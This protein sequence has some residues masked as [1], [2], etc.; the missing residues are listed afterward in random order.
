MNKKNFV[1]LLLVGLFF[2]IGLTVRAQEQSLQK[3]KL[4]DQMKSELRSKKQFPALIRQMEC[5]P[6]AGMQTVPPAKT[7]RIKNDAKNS[8]VSM[9][10]LYESSN[11]VTLWGAVTDG[12]GL[13][14]F[15]A[16]N[17]ITL[18]QYGHNSY[19]VINGGAAIYDGILHFVYWKDYSGYFISKTLYE[20]NV[21]EGGE[22]SQTT[23]SGLTENM[24]AVST[25]YDAN[26]QLTYGCFYNSDMT[27]YEIASIDYTTLDRQLIKETDQLFLAVAINKEGQMYGI[28][29]DGDLYKINKSTGEYE[30]IGATGVSPS[31]TLQSA[32]IDTKSGRMFWAAV[33]NE[34]KSAL[35]DVNL[36]TG[37]AQK[38][39][40]IPENKQI[41]F[42]YC[43]A[44][45]AEDDAPAAITDLNILFEGS[46]TTGT[47]TFTVPSTTFAGGILTGEVDYEITAN[48]T[49]VAQGKANPSQTV[50]TSI[51]TNSGM[52][53]FVVTVSNAAGSSPKAKLEKWVGFDEPN[54]VTNVNLTNEGQEITLTWTASEGTKHGGFFDAE[55]IQYIVTRYPDNTEIATVTGTTTYTETIPEGELKGYSYGVTPLNGDIRGAE[56]KSN[57]VVIGSALNTP[58]EENFDSQDGF[59][60]YTI[61]DA[62]ED[63]KK[64]KY[65]ISRGCAEAPYHFTNNADDWL[66][67]PAIKLST[68]HIY[69]FSF[70]TKPIMSTYPE[71]IEV[72][73]GRGNDPNNYTQLLEPTDVTSDN[74]VRYEFD[75]N[76]AETDEYH[77]AFHAISDADKYGLLVDSISVDAGKSTAGAAAVTNLVAV[78]GEQGALNATIT[79]TTPDKTINEEPI[80]E[81]NKIEIWRNNKDLIK[82][83]ENPAIDTELTYTDNEAGE[84]LN[85]YTI[86]PFAGSNE[87]QKTSVTVYV[88]IDTPLPPANIK[89]RDNQTYVGLTWEQPAEVGAHGGYVASSD[90]LYNLYQISNEGY[91]VLLKGDLPLNDVNLSLNT[92][93][94]DMGLF[95]VA[96]SSKNETGESELATSNVIPTGKS[97]PLPI[98]ESFPKAYSESGIWWNQGSDGNTFR[99]NIQTSADGDGGCVAWRANTP[100]QEAWMSSVKIT[101]DG[102]ETPAMVYS[103][104]ATPDIDATLHVEIHKPDGTFKTMETINMKEF[105]GE[106]GW[107]NSE[108]DLKE[109]INERYIVIKFHGVSNELVVP[110]AID[111]INILDLKNN[112]LN[113]EIT[114]CPEQMVA[115]TDKLISVK[116]RN[117][118]RNGADNYTV[119]LLV[120]G[121]VYD[122]KPASGAL[123]SMRD[124]AF[125]FN[126][127]P[128]AN[129]EGLVKVAARVN[130]EP[131]EN[132]EDNTSAEASIKVERPDWQ[133]IDD[134]AANTD[135]NGNA[136]LNWTAPEFAEPTVVTD[137]FES[138]A[139]WQT[140]DFGH[141]T[142]FDGDGKSTYGITG[143][144]FPH[145]GEAYAYQT[146][147]I[148]TLG[149]DPEENKIFKANSGE[150]MLASFD[151]TTE[152]CDDWLISPVLSGQAQTISFYARSLSN[153][154]ADSF[155]FL[156]SKTSKDTKDFTLVVRKNYIPSAWN[157]YEFEIPEGARYFA[158][159]NVSE[160]EYYISGYAMFIDDIT[161]IPGNATVTGY[162]IYRDGELIGHV[163]ADETSFTDTDD[164]GNEHSYNV[165][166]VYDEG[167]SAFSNTVL[168]ATAI[169]EVLNGKKAAD[170]YTTDGILI[171]Q[172][173]TSTKDLPKGIYIIEGKKAAVK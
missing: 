91:A 16:T 159:R 98:K 164:D 87:G 43:P 162:N 134:L 62:N 4:S 76:I 14:S 77:F 11:G 8:P 68:D 165:T 27:S 135:E 6:N 82:T 172:H 123:K 64:W 141:W 1:N 22:W 52:T 48:G 46:S 73:Y 157:K 58:Y 112:N 74:W 45:E 163:D 18:T 142:T 148:S 70:V 50:N 84:G 72:S 118:G 35:Y 153:D 133:T 169:N 17:P 108:I 83:F 105:N 103:Y 143:L 146:F 93:E 69:K 173:A 131:D 154:N 41:T 10:P 102:T 51:T 12:Y 167:E 107:H 23:R 36:T 121:D 32:T 150:Q 160:D 122:T 47:V 124:A 34:S 26:T 137:D 147:N 66:I 25:A 67:T 24:I 81:L 96:M 37:A 120:D 57:G 15:Q 7:L 42:L 38:I 138:Y 3:P 60:L 31:E 95:Y 130:Y 71:R 94:G 126:Y 65:N 158:I 117:I 40:D 56:T 44:P 161:Y 104:Y 114:S 140:S 89:I 151:A 79:F 13:F 106:E 80:T 115:G 139:S 29:K 144:L 129:V 90:L 75:I 33:D 78:A 55:N 152:A 101:L 119:D 155:E 49:I 88:G 28:S 63:G 30:K 166:V 86:V 5:N 136:K 54:P 128:K 149:I 110:L 99:G 61:I 156:Y 97:F 39:A 168:I 111:N 2:I 125:N 170:I 20:I 171:R 59:N 53:K 109:F 21:E 132:L 127:C 19:M 145:A 85:T 9:I 116:V 100:G 92:D 113:A